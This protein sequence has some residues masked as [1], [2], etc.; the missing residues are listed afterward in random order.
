MDASSAF[1]GYLRRPVSQRERGDDK[2]AAFPTRAGTASAQRIRLIRGYRNVSELF[3]KNRRDKCAVHIRKR[4][5]GSVRLRGNGIP[6]L[7]LQSGIIT[8][9][10]TWPELAGFVLNAPLSSA[11]C[12]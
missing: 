12:G 5:S 10:G 6:G 7:Q 11:M 1:A 9:A 3:V 8:N 2:I 4:V